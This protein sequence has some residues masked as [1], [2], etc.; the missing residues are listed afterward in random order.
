MRPCISI[1][2][3]LTVLASVGCGPDDRAASP[4]ATEPANQGLLAGSGPRLV[5]FYA[6]WSPTR[7][8]MKPVIERLEQ[9]FGDEVDFVWIDVDEAPELVRQYELER[10]PTLI[11]FDDGREVDRWAGE[12]PEPVLRE[13]LAEYAS[14]PQEREATMN[15]R[16]GAITFQGDPLTLI[17]P[18]LAA[19][20]EAPDALLLANDLSQV[21]L[22]SL[23][24]RVR[25]I[26]VVP[27]LD[28]RVCDI[29][30]RR[31]NAEA[32][33]LGDDVAV[34]TISMD[35]PFAQQRW[36]Y[37]G[38]VESIQL[39]SDHRDAEFGLAYGVLIKELR[40]LA[41]SV[42]V[43]DRDG[44]IRYIEIVPEMTSEPNYDA[45]LNMAVSL[46]E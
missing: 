9:D 23:A 22:S 21:S 14:R 5:N 44:I 42:F 19:G 10:Y 41:R 30:T 37:L 34:L 8:H 16:S 6:T 39:L 18:E 1:L 35:L 17:G 20:D 29:Q 7:E 40:L 27:S 45:A 43:V 26:S 46:A 25:I 13:A 24:G 3:A 11:L 32:A 15:E 31:F 33:Q 28:T 12:T 38:N 2:V 36:M 4:A